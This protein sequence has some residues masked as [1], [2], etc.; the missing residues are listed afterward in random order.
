MELKET[1]PGRN[2]ASYNV[3]NRKPW[4][5]TDYDVVTKFLKIRVDPKTLYVHTGDFKYAV[6]QGLCNHH[7]SWGTKATRYVPFGSAFGCEASNKAD[8]RANIDLRGTDF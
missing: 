7:K 2:F 5:K 8:G 4:G 3:P 6:T 1:N